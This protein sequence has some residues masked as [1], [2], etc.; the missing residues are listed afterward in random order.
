MNFVIFIWLQ[1]GVKGIKR[2]VERIVLKILMC[3]EN[4]D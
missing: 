1:L 4:C 3:P 2:A